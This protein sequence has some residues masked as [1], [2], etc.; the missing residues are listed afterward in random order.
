MKIFV[1]SFIVLAGTIGGAQ[2]APEY[3]EWAV[4]AFSSGN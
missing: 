1:L 3:P 4:R 2:A